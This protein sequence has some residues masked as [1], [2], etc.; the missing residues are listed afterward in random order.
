MSSKILHQTCWA[1]TIEGTKIEMFSARNSNEDGFLFIGGVHGDEPEGVEL[2]QKLL[3]WLLKN[4]N[5]TMQSWALIPCLNPDGYKK[6]QRM[7]SQNVDLNRNFP[8]KDWQLSEM[9][10]Y[11]SGPFANSELETQA[12]VTHLKTHN[13]KS[14]I[15]FH[16]WEPCV[17][18]TGEPGKRYAEILSLENNYAVKPSIG[19]PTPGSFGD[20]GWN[21]L[22]TPVICIEE[23]EKIDLKFVWPHF[24]EG[25]QTLLSKEQ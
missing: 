22:G 12:L 25:L 15:H 3:R 5:S 23:Q 21:E 19:Y 16:S 17:V 24:Q 18:Y 4:N 14:I 8:T 1:K 9:N 10:R 13:Y 6:N 7:N 11:F 2:A 20:Y